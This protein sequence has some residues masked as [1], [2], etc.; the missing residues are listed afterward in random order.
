[1]FFC[2]CYDIM[3]L[4]K[5]EGP[6]LLATGRLSKIFKFLILPFLDSGSPVS[7]VKPF[8]TTSGS[9]WVLLYVGTHSWALEISFIILRHVAN[10]HMSILLHQSETKMTN[11]GGTH[12]THGKLLLNFNIHRWHC[13][14]CFL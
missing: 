9:F 2:D 10:E 11:L 1:M 6:H 12:T 4:T 3:L 8:K 5:G 13:G 14:L 7:L